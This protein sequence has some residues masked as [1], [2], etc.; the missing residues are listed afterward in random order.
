M[1][2]KLSTV[3]NVIPGRTEE[4]NIAEIVLVRL[5]VTQSEGTVVEGEDGRRGDTRVEGAGEAGEEGR[6]SSLWVLLRRGRRWKVV[7]RGWRGD[8]RR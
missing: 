1:V 2:L 3:E 4:M 7:V 6:R 8:D 5:G